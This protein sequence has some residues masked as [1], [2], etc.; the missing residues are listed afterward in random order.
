MLVP[1]VSMPSVRASRATGIKRR[2]LG[3]FGHSR[4]S[5][6]KL[7]SEKPRWS[8]SPKLH[9]SWV[10]PLASTKNATNGSA[11]DCEASGSVQK[12][13]QAAPGSASG[14]GLRA[15]GCAAT[16]RRVARDLAARK[17]AQVK[18]RSKFSLRNWHS[19]KCS[20]PWAVVNPSITSAR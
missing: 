11:Q 12:I 3:G 8:E 5:I 2:K 9:L 20:Q 6:L 10:V 18:V 1:F 16:A 13:A 14:K 7:R 15:R 17:A 19:Q 4:S